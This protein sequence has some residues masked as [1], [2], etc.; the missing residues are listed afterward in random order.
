ML[1]TWNLTF[2]VLA[3]LF[4]F[5][6]H[7]E[8]AQVMMHGDIVSIH[9][10]ADTN[11]S[12]MNSTRETCRIGRSLDL[13]DFRPFLGKLFSSGPTREEFNFPSLGYDN[14]EVRTTGPSTRK[15]CR[16][17]LRLS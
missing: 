10:A 15:H 16:V 8:Q 13:Q 14:D 3:C 12:S 9:S 2:A 1:A 6:Q 17:S 5:L 7:D 11:K 4:R